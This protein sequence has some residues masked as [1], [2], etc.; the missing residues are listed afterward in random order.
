MTAERGA[1][2]LPLYLGDDED[3]RS[4]LLC[5]YESLNHLRAPQSGDHMTA[6]IFH[7]LGMIETGQGMNKL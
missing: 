1:I 5:Y 7:P 6:P 4:G 2:S 3:L